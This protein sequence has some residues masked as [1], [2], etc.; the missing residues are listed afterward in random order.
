MLAVAAEKHHDELL[1]DFQQYYQ[2]PLPDLSSDAA[3]S[4]LERAAIL[5]AQLP[6]D[7]RVNKAMNPSFEW[8][9]E[10]NLLRLIEYE[11]HLLLWGMSDSKT[12]GEA[13]RPIPTPSE[14]KAKA[15]LVEVAE[16]VELAVAEAFNL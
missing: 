6:S 7:S 3:A 4:D 9:I 16:S 14:Q 1:A 11:L 2:L 10:A 13:P 5:C 8:S 15:A 12:R